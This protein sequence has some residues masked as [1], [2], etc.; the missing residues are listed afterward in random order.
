MDTGGEAMDKSN[1]RTTGHRGP[2]VVEF[3]AFL[4]ALG[5]RHA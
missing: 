3:V 5:V 2:R 1:G 4:V